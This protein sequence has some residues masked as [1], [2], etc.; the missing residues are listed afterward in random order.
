[1]FSPCIAVYRCCML[2]EEEEGVQFA[3]RPSLLVVAVKESG[4]RLELL[5]GVWVRVTAREG[6]GRPVVVSRT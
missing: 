6:A 1:M 2:S 3:I 4:V 5:G